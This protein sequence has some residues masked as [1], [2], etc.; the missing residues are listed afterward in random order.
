MLSLSMVRLFCASLLTLTLLTH[1]PPV[2]LKEI[3]VWDLD[4]GLVSC[5]KVLKCM[6][7]NIRVTGPVL[8]YPVLLS[9]PLR[10]LTLNFITLKA[11][12]QCTMPASLRHLN[13]SIALLL[14]RDARVSDRDDDGDN[15]DD[16]TMADIDDAE[17]QEYLD[18][19]GWATHLK[20]L[21]HFHVKSVD[22]YTYDTKYLSSLAALSGSLRSLVISNCALLDDNAVVHFAPFTRLD[23]LS[24]FPL[25]PAWSVFLAKL[26]S[27]APSPCMLSHL[28]RRLPG[29]H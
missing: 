29:V 5:T 17:R 4:D 15:N 3:K 14:P 16:A 20:Q 12:S 6:P 23:A 25:H 11:L 22:H 27:H 24:I 2:G 28:H 1:H 9:P 10:S 21:A 13:V 18:W 26:P 8:S 19:L 7:I